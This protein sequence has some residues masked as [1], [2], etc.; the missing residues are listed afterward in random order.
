MAI[1]STRIKWM[2]HTAHMKE[3]INVYNILV[4]KHEWKDQLNPN[5]KVMNSVSMFFLSEFIDT[6]MWPLEVKITLTNCKAK[7]PKTVLTKDSDLVQ[8]CRLLTDPNCSVVQGD[9]S[10]AS[11]LRACIVSLPLLS[12]PSLSSVPVPTPQ[13]V[14]QPEA[15]GTGG[16]HL[17]AIPDYD[18]AATCWQHVQMSCSLPETEEPASTLT[19]SYSTTGSL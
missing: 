13:P 2:G 15:N 1:R 3:V 5:T 8:F 9:C 18:G 14:L 4:E 19:N 16:C 7:L 11:L 10:A 6:R 17:V 12:C